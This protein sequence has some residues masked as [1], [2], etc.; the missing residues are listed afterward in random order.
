MVS[1]F[2]NLRRAGLILLAAGAFATGSVGTASQRRPS[3]CPASGNSKAPFY[4]VTASHVGEG[5]QLHVGGNYRVRESNRKLTLVETGESAKLLRLKLR[6][7]RSSGHPAGCPHFGGS[8]DAAA[9]V[10]RVQITDWKANK[11]TVRVAKPRHT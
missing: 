4:G 6:S 7:I 9:S 1:N 11:I 8:F 10:E 3:T 2:R 5:K